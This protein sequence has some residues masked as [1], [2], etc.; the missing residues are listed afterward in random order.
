MQQGYDVTVSRAKCWVL[1]TDND[2]FVDI[3]LEKRFKTDVPISTER[4]QY[5]RYLTKYIVEH[6]QKSTFYSK[7]GKV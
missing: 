3:V 2:E 1:S 4:R 5:L 6:S 7:L